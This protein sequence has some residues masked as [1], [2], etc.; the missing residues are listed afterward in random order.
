MADLIV[1]SPA[2]N[3]FAVATSTGSALGGPGTQQWLTGW[4]SSPTWARTGDFNGDGKTDLIEAD[5]I[6]GTFNVALSDGTRLDAPGS[7]TWLTGW[8]GNPQWAEVGDFNGDGKDDLIANDSVNNRIVVALSDGRSLRSPRQR[9]LV[10][11]LGRR[12]TS[13]GRRRRLQRRRQRRP[14][15]RQPDNRHLRRHHLHRQPT[16]RPRHRHLAHGVG[17]EPGLGGGR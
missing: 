16:R 7:G 8:G 5:P 14:H 10:H 12:H 13:M 2:T 11:R 9:H 1:A 4:D 3:A 6:A 15:R 17:R